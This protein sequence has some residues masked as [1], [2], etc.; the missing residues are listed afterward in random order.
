MGSMES[1]MA[2]IT[3]VQQHILQE[4]QAALKATGR[5]AS[6]T[7]SWLLSGITLAAKMVEAKIR[8]AGLSDVYGAFGAENVQGSSSRSWM[9]MRIRRCCIAWG[10]AIALRRW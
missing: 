8:S 4:Q 7:F 5:E 2:M 6:G 9:F 3:T 10:C 1:A